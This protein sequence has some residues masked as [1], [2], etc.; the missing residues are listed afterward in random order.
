MMTP[1]DSASTGLGPSESFVILYHEDMPAARKFYE[2][3]LGLEVSWTPQA[4]P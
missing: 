2:G 3:V 4:T 1:D